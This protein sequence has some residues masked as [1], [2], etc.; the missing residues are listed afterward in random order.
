VFLSIEGGRKAVEEMRSGCV[1]G[2]GRTSGEDGRA[3]HLGD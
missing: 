1:I 3:S 2:V